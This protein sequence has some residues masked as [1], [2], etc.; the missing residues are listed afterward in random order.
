MDIEAAQTARFLITAAL[1]YANG[2]VHIG[3]LAGCYLPA[4]IYAR[5]LRLRGKEVLFVC[6]TDEHGVAITI[7]ARKEGITPQAL[8]DKYHNLIR[9]SFQQFGISFDIF[10][11]TSL[12]LHH[13]TAS[14]FFTRFY[15]TGQLIETET[16][17]LYDPE[18]GMFLADRYI[19][20]TCPKCSYDH[21]YGDQCER[22]GSSLSPTDLIDPHSTLSGARPELR[23]TTH[24]FLPL[25]R[26][27]QQMEDYILK[28]HSEWK[29]NVL[30]QCKSWLQEGLQP[31]A[32]T[33]DMD[34]GVPVPLSQATGKVMYVWFDAPIGYISATRHWAEL[35]NNPDAWKPYW[36]KA[37]GATQTKLIHFI[38]KDNIVFHCIIFPV[39]LMGHGEYIWADQ[40]PANEFLNLEGQKISTSR[41]WAVWLHEYLADFPDKV[42]VLRY[43]L[44]ATMPETKDNDFTWKDFQT[45]NNS[46]LLAVLGN[47]VNR[48]VAFTNKNFEAKVPAFTHPLPPEDQQAL[49][50]IPEQQ[51]RISQSLEAFH[52][53]EALQEVMNLARIG[54]KYLGDLAPWHLIKTDPARAAGVLRVS[55]EICAALSTLLAPF[56]PET[57]DKICQ[58]L[59]FNRPDWNRLV[60]YTPD[61]HSQLLTT[62]N[63]LNK[64]IH[65]FQRIEDAAIE[66]Q[67]AKLPQQPVISPS[68]STLTGTTNNTIMPSKPEITIEDFQK[69]D[70]R[71]ATILAAEKVKGADKL[72]K[73]TLD[74][75]VDQRT[76][77][78][79]IAQ[80]YRPEDLVGKQILI[81]ANLAP[82]KLRGIDSMGMALLAENSDGKLVFVSPESTV[83]AGAP[84][85]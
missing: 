48:A 17:Q 55:L 25:N 51:Q 49:A 20:G 32:M 8:V 44:C 76:I 61:G 30:G 82:R 80:H 37:A 58:L 15:E 12:P 27:Q 56:L 63:H 45:R 60:Q 42:D 83:S 9:D 26:Y 1:P 7:K 43:V 41:N 64:E 68:V 72:L 52:F 79:G 59:N 47:F 78:S 14:E 54:N 77:V 71:I 57:A 34:W 18:V 10:S 31:R 36:L 29:P 33:R 73:L 75:G 70:L 40:I 4:D 84:V 2:P 53:R 19:I 13:E 3:H 81:L 46:E 74:T 67:I 23:K 65:L 66:A 62:N 24:W 35:Q 5:Y 16:E 21:A 22:C 39:L 38:G 11:R 69:C 6:G 85:A 28:Q 50:A